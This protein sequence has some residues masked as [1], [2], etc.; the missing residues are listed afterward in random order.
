[1]Q[2]VTITAAN[3]EER[4]W[5][6]S[7]MAGSEPW[8]TLGRGFEQCRKP[9]HDPDFQMF[10]AHAGALPC[11]FVLLQRCGVAGSPYIASIAVAEEFRG[12]GVGTRLLE[13][14]EDF[15]RAQ[16]RHIFLCV[17]S[18]NDRAR[19]LYEQLD[20]T[21]VGEFKD[22]VIPGASEILMHKRLRQL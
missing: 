12:K 21:P 10:V 20:Y 1:M 22:Y 18:F 5:A 13:F 9:C 14:A 2:P 4:D 11:G 16:S 6:A 8:V 15:F 7:L 3:E 19:K 17:S